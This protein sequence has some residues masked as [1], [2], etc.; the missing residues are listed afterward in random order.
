MVL[1]LSARLEMNDP[2]LDPQGLVQRSLQPG[3]KA[4]FTWQAGSYTAGDTPGVLWFYE[5]A[6]NGENNVLYAKE[7][8]YSS[9]KFLGLAPS[10]ARF[11]AAG[12]LLIGGLCLLLERLHS[13]KRKITSAVTEKKQ[14]MS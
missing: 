3:G 9:Y 2:A 12:L 13:R 5:T 4:L 6:A 14:E 10:T 7:F 1:R 11:A 8:T